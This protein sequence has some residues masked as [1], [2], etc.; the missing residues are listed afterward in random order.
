MLLSGDR[1]VT[2]TYCRMKLWSIDGQCLNTFIMLT[3]LINAFLFLVPIVS[4]VETQEYC[5]YGILKV[6][7]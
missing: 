3:L 1:V 4:S 5:A 6:S 7:C 2:S